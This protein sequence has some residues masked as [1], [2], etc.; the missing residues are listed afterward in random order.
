MKVLFYAL[1][2]IVDEQARVY[3]P[4]QWDA[5]TRRVKHVWGGLAEWGDQSRD[6]KTVLLLCR[7]VSV[8]SRYVKT[9]LLLLGDVKTVKL[10]VSSEFFPGRERHGY[11]I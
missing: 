2:C 8:Q 10:N 7:D 3:W 9:E 11:R 1:Q 6:V 4:L 5:E